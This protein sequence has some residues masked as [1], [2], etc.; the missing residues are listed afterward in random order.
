MTLIVQFMAYLALLVLISGVI[1]RICRTAR[2]PVHLRWELYPVPHERGRAAYGGSILEEVNWWTKPRQVD[3]LGTIRAMLRE[4]LFLKG[5]F[6]EQRFLWWGSFPLHWGL[7]LLVAGVTL[8]LA[9]AAMLWMGAAGLSRYLLVIVPTLAWSSYLL[10]ALGT[11]TLLMMRLF[12]L[13][14]RSYSNLSHYFN[15]LLLGAVFASGLVWLAVDTAGIGL[16]QE[17]LM[18]LIT[19]HHLPQLSL[20]EVWHVGLVLFFMIYFPFTHMT[21]AFMKF[22]TYHQVRWEDRPNVAGGKLQSKIERM[23]NQPVTWSA[24]HIKAEDRK[25]WVDLAGETGAEK[26]S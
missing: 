15:L 11:I 19:F 9:S 14:L 2:M 22:F 6:E 16:S 10:G 7:Y 17:L 1:Y 4:I 18:G 5:I 12:S 13:K 26:K 20:P 24:P 8:T 23:E 21:H 25:T 3:H